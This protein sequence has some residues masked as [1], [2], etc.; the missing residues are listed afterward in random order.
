MCN[1]CGLVA[2]RTASLRCSHVFCEFC[3]EQCTDG[4]FG[5]ERRCV[6]DRDVFD[7]GTVRWN[8]TRPLDLV[9]AKVRCWNARYGCDF[10]GPLRGLL[11]H[12]EQDCSFHAVICPRCQSMQVRSKLAD[13]YRGGCVAL[14]TATTWGSHQPLSDSASGGGRDAASLAVTQDTLAA[15]ESKMNE[16]LEHLR[17]L[18]TRTSLLQTDMSNAKE[19]L[20]RLLPEGATGEGVSLLGVSAGAH[21]PA[22]R[23]GRLM[24]SGLEAPPLQD[25]FRVSLCAA[26]KRAP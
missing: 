4:A 14:P 21:I 7:V 17:A 22:A 15:F 25:R 3:L 10:T 9:K 8:E 5:E 24:A 6:F 11:D 23:A 16:L 1:L 13:H 26:G 20:E 12:F 2:R 19:A 18:G